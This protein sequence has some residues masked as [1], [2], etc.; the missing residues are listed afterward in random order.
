MF[1][2]EI[3]VIPGISALLYL[4]ALPN[5]QPRNYTARGF[6]SPENKEKDPQLDRANVTDVSNINILVTRMAIINRTTMPHS[7]C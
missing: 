4:T 1:I 6:E 3:F 2:P 7:A 5:I